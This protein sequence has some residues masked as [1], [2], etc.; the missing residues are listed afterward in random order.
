MEE[1]RGSKSWREELA[2][3][4][5]DSGIRFTGDAIGVSTPAFETKKFEFRSPEHEPAVGSESLQD[6]IKGFAKAWGEMV[7]E[8]GKG[9]KD[10]VQQTILTEDSYIV[11]KTRRPLSMASE[12]VRFLNEFLPEDRDPAHAWLVIFCVFILA[13]AVLGIHH[14]HDC[15]VPMV[16]KVY[17]PPPSAVRIQLPDGRYLAYHELGVPADRA[18]FS[19]IVPH[20]FISSRLAGIP[21]IKLSL[22]EEFGVRLVTYDRPGFGE[23]DPHPDRNHNSSA[24]DMLQLAESVGIKD[25]FWILGYSDGAMHAWAAL[26][27]IP[28]RVAGAA[29]FAPLVNPY[30]S[31][32]TKEEM[33]RTWEKWT[34]KRKFMYYLARRFPKLLNYFYRRTFLSGKHGQIDK[35][36]SLSLGKKDKDL[37]ETPAFEELWQRN[38]EESI[39]Q[40]STKPFL[41][42][43]VLQVSNWGFSLGDLQPQKKCPGK[44]FLPWLK[45]LYGEAECEMTGFLG[46]IHIWQGMDDLVVPP[47]MTAYVSRIL[48]NASV[49]W[50]PEEG[51]YSYFFLCDKCHREIL[52]SLFGSPQGPLKETPSEDDEEASTTLNDP[53]LE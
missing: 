43:A 48:P 21:G 39:R 1:V 25:K 26:K 36:L 31:S 22:L 15:S 27:Y 3:L 18:R 51:H 34:R 46:P 35:W 12:K 24:V 4:V 30:D 50:L 41:E 16:K 20:G 6:Q 37:I 40:G 33:S 14:R 9:C 23:S 49:H 42:E 19:L 8:F 28:Q 47:T 45:F 44:G 17:I 10:V 32:M 7:L 29:M 5:D 2:S 38:V 13:F 53:L 11:K 52:T